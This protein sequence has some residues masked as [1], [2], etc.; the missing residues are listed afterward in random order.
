MHQLLIDV[1]SLRS[2]DEVR[3][4]DIYAG[5]TRNDSRC[6]IQLSRAL[7]DLWIKQKRAPGAA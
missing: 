1:G 7:A 3:E 6:T 4:G 5:D 2:G